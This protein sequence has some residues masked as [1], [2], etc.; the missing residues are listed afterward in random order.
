LVTKA[1]GVS[2]HMIRDAGGFDEYCI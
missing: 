2:G 1:I